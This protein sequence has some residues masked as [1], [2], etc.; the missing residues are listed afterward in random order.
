VDPLLSDTPYIIHICY[1][2]TCRLE[3]RPLGIDVINVVPGAVRSNIANSTMAT[4]NRM[5]ELKLYKPFEAAIRERAYFSQGMKS[6]PTEEFAK[7]TVAAVLKKN[8]PA[9]FSYGHY[10]TIMAIMHHLP[11]FI[12]DFLI[13]KAMKC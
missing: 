10:S 11:L 4:Y 5:P 3:L 9:W 8:P 2:A 12:R 1:I 6:T 7:N 13:K